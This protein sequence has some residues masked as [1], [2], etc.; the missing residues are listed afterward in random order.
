M[1]AEATVPVSFRE[2]LD[3]LAAR[4]LL[5]TNASAA[6][7]ATLAPEIRQRAL[8]SARTESAA[9]LQ[10][11]RDT[12]RAILQP[13]SEPGAG[14]NDARGRELLRDSLREI[15]YQP[16][17][18]GAAP[19]SLRDLGS[20]Q[21][22]QLI[23]DMQVGMARGYGYYAQGANAAVLDQWP[24]QEFLRVEPRDRPRGDDYW[25]ARWLGAGGRTFP[26]G[27]MVALKD[28]DVW[29]NLSA[30]GLPYPPFD[31]GSGMGVQDVS[32]ADAEALG[33]LGPDDDVQVERMPFADGLPAA[34]LDPLDANDPLGAAILDAF[35][36]SATFQD[37]VLR[38]AQEAA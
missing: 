4:R 6:D 8:F 35:G 13:S 33:L 23:L 22:L 9:H 34:A 28:S 14:V 25:R 15:G 2:A 7:L 18:V 10:R 1:P 24:A 12:V 19:G 26:G 3:A 32:R 5:P 11:I 21:R 31:Y 37:G 20:R 17:S 30:F 38:L 27:R 36:D 29:T 16:D